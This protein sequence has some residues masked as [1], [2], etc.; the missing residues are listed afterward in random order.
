MHLLKNQQVQIKVSV[1]T[2]DKNW[3]TNFIKKKDPAK[4]AQ[5]Y[6]QYENHRNL[7]STLLKKKA[8]KIIIRNTSS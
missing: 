7:L 3:F 6:V 5:L 2:M 8:K 1:E 4:K